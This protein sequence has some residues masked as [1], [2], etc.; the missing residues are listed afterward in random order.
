MSV[1][2]VIGTWL[3]G[4]AGIA[5]FVA[6]SY[7]FLKFHFGTLMPFLKRGSNEI[8]RV[9]DKVF[10]GLVIVVVWLAYAGS[11]YLLHTGYRINAPYSELDGD[12]YEMT[13]RK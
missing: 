2:N 7:G 5:G 11:T 6:M 3:L 10:T 8:T 4:L 1:N 13:Y 9:A 12:D